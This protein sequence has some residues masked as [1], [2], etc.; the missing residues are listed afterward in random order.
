[1]R[2]VNHIPAAVLVIAFT[3]TMAWPKTTAFG[4][5]PAFQVPAGQRQLFLDDVGIAKI[6]NLTRTMYQ[7]NKKGAVIRPTYPAES[8]MQTRCAPAGG[9]QARLWKIWLINSGDYPGSAYAQ[10]RD[11]LHWTKPSLG[12]VEVNGTRENSYITID[13]KLGWCANAIINVVINPDDPDPA[14][15]FTGLGHASGREPVVSADG[16]NWKS[17]TCRPSCRGTNRT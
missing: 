17:W 9:P 12:Q 15:R 5:D 4:A 16:I 13:E 8:Y 7:P 11:G 10:S 2:Q 6:E 14:R 1:M 3:L